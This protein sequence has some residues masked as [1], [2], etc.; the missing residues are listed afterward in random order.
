MGIR[1]L[2]PLEMAELAPVH[3]ASEKTKV[4]IIPRLA[5][6]ASI[7]QTMLRRCISN[8]PLARG[9]RRKMFT[10]QLSQPCV[11]FNNSRPDTI[12]IM[13][14]RQWNCRFD[15]NLADGLANA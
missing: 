9:Y 13:S 3:G 7:H 4:N 5:S 2:K 8:Q 12:Q 10:S 15:A 11:P 1:L 6:D 14:I